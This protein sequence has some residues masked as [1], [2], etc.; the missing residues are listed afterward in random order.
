MQRRMTIQGVSKK[1]SM[2]WYAKILVLWDPVSTSVKS[3]SA[4]RGDILHRVLLFLI[5]RTILTLKHVLAQEA[6]KARFPPILRH[7]Q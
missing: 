3:T 2:M 5:W 6:E 4:L 1:E 7:F